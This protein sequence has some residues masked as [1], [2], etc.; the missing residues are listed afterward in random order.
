MKS[1]TILLLTILLGNL[2]M[3]AEPPAG[4]KDSETPTAQ[5]AEEGGEAKKGVRYRAGK[6]VNFE[7]LLI[8]GQIQR[9]EISVVTGNTAQG[10]DGLLRLRENFLDRVTIDFG[11]EIP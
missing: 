1:Q 10:S 3:A 8:N 11:E 2:A 6:D 4:A 5:A 7:E 9:P